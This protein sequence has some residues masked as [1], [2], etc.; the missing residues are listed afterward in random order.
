MLAPDEERGHANPCEFSPQIA[1]RK[2]HSSPQDVERAGAQ[3]VGDDRRELRAQLVERRDKAQALSELPTTARDPRRSNERQ[4]T[5]TL[6]P[7]RRQLGRHEPAERMTDQVDL[8]ESNRAEPPAEPHDE[9]GR[10]Q[11]PA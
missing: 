9:I 11:S 6:G 10:A 3:R 4:A 5:K 1:L 7:C 8:L 2:E